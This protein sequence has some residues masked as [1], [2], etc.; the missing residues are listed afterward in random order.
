M[1]AEYIGLPLIKDDAAKQFE[2]TVEGHKSFIRFNETPHH[3]TLVHTEVPAA[4]EGKGV[5]TT[6]VEKTLEYIEQSGKTLI[7]LCPFVF[8]YIKRHPDWKRIV[9]PG[10]KGFDH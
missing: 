2:L 7:P 8:A 6:L 3:I 4:L 1:K 10:F 5:G 9:D